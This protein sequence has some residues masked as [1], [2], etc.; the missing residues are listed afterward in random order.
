[1]RFTKRDISR[2]LFKNVS[3]FKLI[4][5][6]ICI[7]ICLLP[8]IAV[9][10]VGLVVFMTSPSDN[11]TSPATCI[12]LSK[13]QCITNN[14]NNNLVHHHER[15][16]IHSHHHQEEEIHTFSSSSERKLLAQPHH[17]ASS[18]SQSSSSLFVHSSHSTFTVQSSSSSDN[19]KHASLITTQCTYSVSFT[20]P[21]SEQQQQHPISA[22]TTIKS[23]IIP[24][25]R[26]SPYAN[27]TLQDRV[28][29]FYDPRNPKNVSFEKTNLI[30]FYTIVG[31]GVIGAGACLLLLVLI[32]VGIFCTNFC[33]FCVEYK[34]TKRKRRQLFR[35]SMLHKM[36]TMYG[37]SGES[38]DGYTSS[39][40]NEGGARFG[41]NHSSSIEGILNYGST[42]R[43]RESIGNGY[44]YS[45]A[46]KSPSKF[47]N[48]GANSSGSS[49]VMLSPMQY[50]G[51]LSSTQVLRN[52]KS[53]HVDE[54]YFYQ[55]SD[56]EDHEN[57]LSSSSVEDVAVEIVSTPNH[58]PS[59][60]AQN[61]Y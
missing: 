30:H 39:S 58:P 34:K 52:D 10:I 40:S 27:Y 7:G 59:F 18:L 15:R 29:C 3:P 11:I 36:I 55:H 57:T 37:S 24:F 13:L 19:T 42:D 41:L 46:N 2:L 14:K 53:F 6:G 20:I 21:S 33:R 26:D 9:L 1:M 56:D 4:L 25:P 12:I 16:V 28:P 45:N 38:E 61:H 44:Y 8:A 43:K 48:S 54:K 22:E 60:P 5:H 49:H 35:K 51:I 17:K 32:S 31:L 23:S 47:R 50:Q